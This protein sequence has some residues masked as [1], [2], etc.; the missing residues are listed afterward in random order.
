MHFPSGQLHAKGS[1]YKPTWNDTSWNIIKC[2]LFWHFPIQRLSDR[3]CQKKKLISVYKWNKWKYAIFSTNNFEKVIDVPL[4]YRNNDFP[5]YIFSLQMRSFVR[6]FLDL[7]NVFHISSKI[8]RYFCLQ[9][10]IDNFLVFTR[11]TKYARKDLYDRRTFVWRRTE[12]IQWWTKFFVS[13]RT[14]ARNVLW[15]WIFFF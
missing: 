11:G 4:F 13:T 3:N 7:H 10:S 15:S 2:I 12:R 6:S 9:F 14:Q 5:L 8:D 1:F